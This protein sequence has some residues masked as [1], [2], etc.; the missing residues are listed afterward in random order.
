[1]IGEERPLLEADTHA[2]PIE[3]FRRWF[4]EALDGGFVE[5]T[6]VALATA[7]KAGQPSV[8]MVLLKGYDA[9]GFVFF[10][11]YDSR[12]GDELAANPRASLLFWWDK[13][14]RQIRIEGSLARVSDDESDAYFLSRARGSQLSAAASP[15]SRP[16]ASRQALEASVAEL[17]A[18]YDGK[19]V[20]RP[21]EW[22]GYRL[23][24]EYLEFWQGRRDRLHDRIC[25]QRAQD[26]S[27]T[28]SR[29]GP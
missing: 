28:R 13:L 20:P 18:R 10:T 15:Q 21:A 27:W 6:A 9:R 2:D 14:Y 12:K 29:I 3:Q 1:M 7:S 17:A 8:R 5:P 22:G 4:A 19:A 26:G 24:P 16:V 23:S 25:Y 11:N